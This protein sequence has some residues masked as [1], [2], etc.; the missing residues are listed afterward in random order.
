MKITMQAEI[1]EGMLKIHCADQMSARDALLVSGSII[2]MVLSRL[3]LAPDTREKL[4]NILKSLNDVCGVDMVPEPLL[5]VPQ[6]PAGKTPWYRR[7]L[8]G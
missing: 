1:E 5:Q 2:N 8:G 3:R 6:P 7:I 4:S